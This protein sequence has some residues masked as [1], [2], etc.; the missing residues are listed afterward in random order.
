MDLS[1]SGRPS[2]DPR[3]G[4]AR[5]VVHEGEQNLLL[6][7]EVVVHEAGRETGRPRDEADGRS[8][9]PP[10]GHDASE[11]RHDL[12]PACQRI[13]GVRHMLVNQPNNTPRAVPCQRSQ[14]ATPGV[15]HL[16]LAA[17]AG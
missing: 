11:A 7:P 9:V 10:L 12:G 3:L 14:P 8:L 4:A 13:L 2:L 17:E 1:R 15:V 5:Q 6:A 16:P